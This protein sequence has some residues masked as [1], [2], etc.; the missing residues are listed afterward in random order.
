MW[1]AAALVDGVWTAIDVIPLEGQPFS[2]ESVWAAAQEHRAQLQSS[3]LQHLEN[4]KSTLETARD[5]IELWSISA[6]ADADQFDWTGPAKIKKLEEAIALY[7][8]STTETSAPAKPATLAWHDQTAVIIPLTGKEKSVIIEYQPS[9]R[10]ETRIARL[11]YRHAGPDHVLETIL[12]WRGYFGRNSAVVDGWTK[13]RSAGHGFVASIGGTVGFVVASV[14]RRL[15]L[16]P[17]PTPE[18]D[19]TAQRRLIALSERYAHIANGC[20]DLSRI[21]PVDHKCAIVFVHGMVSCGIVGLKDLYP[22][23][24]GAIPHPIYRYEHD[25]FRPL[26]ENASELTELIYSRIHTQRL[27]IAAHSRGGLV[28]RLALDDLLR[29]GYGGQIEV[30]TFGTPHLGT[31]L[32]EVGG[33]ALNLIYKLGEDFVGSVPWMTP[34]T[35]ANSY[36]VDAPSLPRGI[37]VMREH[38]DVMDL[39]RRLGS[40]DRVHSYG[41]AFDIATA[42]SGFGVVVE[43]ALLGAFGERSHDLLV[44]TESSL[45]FGR[46][47]RALGCSHVHYFLEPTVQKA[48]KQYC[49][50]PAPSPDHVVIGGIR[51]PISEMHPPDGK[52][53]EDDKHNKTSTTRSRVPWNEGRGGRPRGRGGR[54]RGGEGT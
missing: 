31:P 21:N 10:D 7:F 37:A 34:L 5:A 41:S 2:S 52:E 17:Q 25:T 30:Y 26:D 44:P 1:A 49:P 4:E 39:L 27:L 53:K 8:E 38:S 19:P 11:R 48:I 46:A 32:V 3:L 36:L 40:S 12:D 50:A 24:H 35:K 18:R 16:V 47:E 43:G 6:Q 20:P 22:A 23:A 13:M 33:K 54:G 29:R 15:T 42:P 28:A 45:G 14:L 9:L 51:V